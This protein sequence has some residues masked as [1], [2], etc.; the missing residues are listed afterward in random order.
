LNLVERLL[1]RSAQP[2]IIESRRGRDRAT[3]FA[4]LAERSARAAT[5][6]E[7]NGVSAGDHVLFLAP[8]SAA[9]YVWLL[10]TL[11]LGAVAMFLDPAAG[12]AH[13][14]RCLRLLAPRAFVGSTRAHLL[15]LLVP[16]LRRVPA[17][18]CLDGWLPFCLSEDEQAKPREALAPCSADH[19]A[20]ITFTSGSTGEPKAVVRSHG[21]LLEQHRVLE[22]ALEL[23]PGAS[24][25]TTLPIFLLANIASGVTSVI[26]EGD[27]RR[28]GAIDPLPIL[29]QLRRLRPESCGAAPAFVERLCDGCEQTG[30][31]LASL[32]RL[33][34]GGGPVFPNLI[35]R[36]KRRLPQGE[37]I[38]L[39]GSTEAEPIAHISAREIGEHDYE[40]MRSGEGL[41]AGPPIEEIELAVLPDRWG[42][43]LGSYSAESFRAARLPAGEAGEIVVSG[44][45]VVRGY[46]LG[47]GDAETKFDAGGARWHRTGDLGRIDA[48]GRLWLLGRCAAAIRDARGTLYPFA[49]ECAAQQH[50]GVRRA[51]LAVVNGRRVLAYEA[52]E[53]VEQDLSWAALDEIRRVAAIPLDARHNSKIDYPALTRLLAS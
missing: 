48:Q 22:K 51:A 47:R 10:G 42:E 13:A 18:V 4:E 8:M 5:V 6:L 45:H 35:A 53:K 40:R 38:A 15:R 25:L 2:A 39:Y 31:K 37:V 49:V 26:P 14:A 32:R 33:Y 1:E 11:R 9:L 3:S 7:S 17:Q 24:D 44:G 29:G 27:L 36:A 41:L 43:P 28:P 16:E 30:D 52:D 12:R 23:R 46:L 50:P 19:P 34:V 20:L 21:F